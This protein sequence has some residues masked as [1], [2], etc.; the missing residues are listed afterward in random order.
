MVNQLQPAINPLVRKMMGLGEDDAEKVE[1]SRQ[2]IATVL[3]FFEDKLGNP[4]FAGEQFTLAEVAAGTIM[5]WLPS[6]GVSLEAYP[7]L[8]DWLE[9]LMQRDSWQQTQ[10]TPEEIEAFKPQA[11]RLM[12]KQEN[13]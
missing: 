5:C 13:R 4:Y 3:T 10:P 1:R 11:R 12:A 9:G 7:K 8:R 6:M 2:R